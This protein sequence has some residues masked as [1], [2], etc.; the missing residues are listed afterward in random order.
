[1]S[2]KFLVTVEEPG[3]GCG[4]LLGLG[5]A[6]VVLILVGLMP[7]QEAQQSTSS[8][9]SPK[10]EA[11]GSAE[12][13]SQPVQTLMRTEPVPDSPRWGAFATSPSAETSGWGKNYETAEAAQQAAI[14]SCGQPD[15][16]ASSAFNAGGAALVESDSN[17][18][19][20]WEQSSEQD[21]INTALEH[22]RS[23]EPEGNCRLK[24]SFSF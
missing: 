15:C 10:Q 12:P 16:V 2:K 6:A 5:G 23:E 20:S 8:D 1:M 4:P 22:C 13:A 17:W 7:T 3:S 24:D 18:Y 9:P 11:P 21:A 19:R 14:E